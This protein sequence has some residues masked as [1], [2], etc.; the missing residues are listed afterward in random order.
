MGIDE[1]KMMP[2]TRRIR[3]C[4]KQLKEGHGEGRIKIIGVREEESNKR[5]GRQVVMLGKE[6]P[7]G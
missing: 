5:K 4:C 3:Y 6:S 7:L 1:K 2:P